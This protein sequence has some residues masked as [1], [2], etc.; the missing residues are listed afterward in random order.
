MPHEGLLA[1]FLSRIRHQVLWLAR[2]MSLGVRGLVLDA[3]D[4]VFLVRHTYIEGWY[5]PGGGVEAGESALMA[6]TRELEE[7]GNIRLL[8][9][10]ILHGFYFNKHMSHRDHVA[11]YIVRDFQQTAPRLPDREIAEAGFFAV[12]ALPA[13]TTRATRMRLAEVFEGTA[14]GQFW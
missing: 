3:Q 8:G 13:G 4:R 7:E 6:L 10:P 14:R 11:C 9:E 2:P 12:D 5:L 1:S